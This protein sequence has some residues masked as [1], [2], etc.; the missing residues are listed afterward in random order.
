MP[1]IKD[2][3][4]LAGVSVMTASR[5]INV[6]GAVAPHTKSK[7][8]RAVNELGYR[9][10]LTARSLR[11]R[12]S[13][14]FGLLLPDIENP[15]FASLAKYV[16]EAAHGYGYS[17]MLGNTWEDPEREAKHFELMMARRMDGIIMSPVSSA[18]EDLIRNSVA[19]VVLLDRSLDHSPS[20][21]VR[22]DGREVGRLAARHLASLG[23]EH[24][25]CISGPLHIDLFAERVEGFRE[26][27]SRAGMRVDCMVSADAISR[28]ESG[29]KFGGELLRK[30]R[31]RPL[32]VF[33]ANDITAFGAMLA[34]KRRGLAVPE[35]VAFV[36]VDD[37][38]FCEMALP[39]LTTVRQPFREI[40]ATAVRL[41]IEMLK[42]RDC[43]PE[44]M[45]LKPELVVRE[46]TAGV[47]RVK[48]GG[49]KAAAAK[50]GAGA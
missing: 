3:A 31:V 10:N 42:N 48:A 7:V 37:I 26:E 12:R 32:A 43:K 19:P 23:H 1:S 41:L 24:F 28:I 8:M 33:C 16:E 18:N 40:A 27:L 9:P 6:S 45:M 30:C 22:V 17:V 49:G 36:G 14:L 35:D 44:N 47:V 29:E 34:A 13:E 25:G 46:S 38:S 50:A 11:M 39:T 4:R 20:P 21:S 2:V 5:V 15:V